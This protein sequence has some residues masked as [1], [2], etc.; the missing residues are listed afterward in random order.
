MLCNLLINDIFGKSVSIYGSCVVQKEH[1]FMQIRT[2]KEENINKMSFSMEEEALSN[3]LEQYK[4][5]Y[6]KSHKDFHRKDIKKNTWN[7]AAE[8]VGLEHSAEAEKEFTKLREKYS[9]YKQDLK[10]KEELG[11]SSTPA[12]KAKKKREEL[13]YL[14]WLDKYNR[15]NEKLTSKGKWLFPKQLLKWKNAWVSFWM[16]KMMMVIKTPKLSVKLTLM[17]MVKK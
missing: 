6:E 17:Q 8:E 13:N 2:Q 9:R 4:I 5:L 14:S 16:S 7:A 3:C 12:Q 10:K 11:I 1:F 15:E